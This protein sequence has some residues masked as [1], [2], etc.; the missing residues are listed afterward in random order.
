LLGTS[1]A[2]ATPADSSA[3]VKANANS[4]ETIQVSNGCGHHRHRNRSGH[5]VPNRRGFMK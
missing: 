5:C 2:T 1:I 3:I 4:R